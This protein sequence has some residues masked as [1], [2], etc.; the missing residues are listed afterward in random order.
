MSRPS[1]VAVIGQLFQF[2]RDS[3]LKPW[4][5]SWAAAHSSLGC[6]GLPESSDRVTR[7]RDLMSSTP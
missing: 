2:R 4:P 3:R 5:C 1:V 7:I 6:N